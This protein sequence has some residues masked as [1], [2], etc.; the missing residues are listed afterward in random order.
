MV[1]NI[2]APGTIEL[3]GVIGFGERVDLMASMRYRIEELP[4]GSRSYFPPPIST[5]FSAID[6]ATEG[7]LRI[8]D[9]VIAGVWE[10]DASILEP[11]VYTLDAGIEFEGARFVSAATFDRFDGGIDISV[12]SGLDAEGRLAS[13][14]DAPISGTTVDVQERTATR[15][16][17][18]L[19]ME[20]DD[21][22]RIEDI[23]ADV[24][25]GRL[26]GRS[27]LDLV[28]GEWELELDLED[29]ALRDLTRQHDAEPAPGTI[30]TVLGNL[31]ISG[32]FDEPESKLGRGR[33]VIDEGK[34]TDSPLVLSVVQ[35]SQFMLPVSG[36]FDFAEIGFMIDG[37]RMIVDD[38]ILASPTLQLVGAGE[39]SLKDWS[40][41]MRLAPKGTVPILSDLIGG[42]TSTLYAIRLEG[43]IDAP[44]ATLEPLPL[45]GGPARIDDPAED[46]PNPPPPDASSQSSS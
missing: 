17:A 10:E 38:V 8:D 30:G 3:E 20:G 42:V 44:E 5:G 41:A 31:A 18:R 9:G 14:I 46:E 24:S 45:L 40:L 2:P 29:A 28:P 16:R 7:P 43:T 32:R 15:P 6:F 26:V 4:E 12:R 11:T 39:M 22:L 19:V 27:T 13:H 21:I 34:M 36:N 37:N 35:L 33:I 23:S 25:G 1:A